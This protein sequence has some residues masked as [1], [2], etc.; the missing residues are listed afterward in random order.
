MKSF[1]TLRFFVL[2]AIA[3]TLNSCVTEPLDSSLDTSN[4]NTTN[5]SGIYKWS[6]KLDGVLYQWEG[7][8]QNPEN[9]GGNYAA[10]NNKGMLNLS[11]LEN[12]FPKLIIIIQFPNASTG[13]FI[14]NSSSPTNE[15]FTYLKYYP[16]FTA[17][18]FT[19]AFG[20]TMNA[21]ISSLSSTTLVANPTNPGK[22]IGT[23]SGTIKKG[24]STAL[25]TISEGIFEVPRIQ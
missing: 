11:L 9:G 25:Y 22:V 17:D 18:T 1:K 2:F 16:N 19:S 23:F 12:S 13:N 24:G 8:L 15:G 10:I 14:F 4:N 3:L 7:T 5:S 20:G 6:C 21:N